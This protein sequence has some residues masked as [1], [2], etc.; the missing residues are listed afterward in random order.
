[1]SFEANMSHCSRHKDK[2]QR[3][4]TL[5]DAEEARI[6]NETLIMAKWGNYARL[7]DAMDYRSN[8][9][10]VMRAL[11]LCANKGNI[12]AKQA[13]NKLAR[14]Y[15]EFNAEVQEPGD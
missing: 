8:D 10:L 2:I 11:V 13:L 12:E 3:H 5:I 4:Q 7:L 1:M 6:T 14:T 15:A 9:Q